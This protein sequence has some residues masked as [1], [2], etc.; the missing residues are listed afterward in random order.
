[1][2]SGK[3]AAGNSLFFQAPKIRRAFLGPF[4]R[5]TKYEIIFAVSITGALPV[6]GKGAL[7]GLF[8]VVK[9]IRLFAIDHGDLNGRIPP[10]FYRLKKKEGSTPA[11]FWRD[12]RKALSRGIFFAIGI[13][14][15]AVRKKT[16]SQ[17]FFWSFYDA[18]KL[19]IPFPFRAWK[20]EKAS[21]RAILTQLK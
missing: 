16:S 12:K 13:E 6:P 20:G 7:P 1:L 10:F 5:W 21:E 18:H 17:V 11:F 3:K 8:F 2:S 9:K 4:F 14:G 19:G 15:F